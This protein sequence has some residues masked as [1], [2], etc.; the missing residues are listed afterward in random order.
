MVPKEGGPRSTTT[1]SILT[2][3]DTSSVSHQHL[4]HHQ[5]DTRSFCSHTKFTA[6]R[7]FDRNSLSHIHAAATLAF[8][9][10]CLDI[11]TEATNVLCH[12][13][14]CLFAILLVAFAASLLCLS[15]LPPS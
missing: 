3:A 15:P 12:A 4:L 13:S 2:P 14:L 5:S 7:H 11:L 1:L 8:L 6:L 10:C 9:A